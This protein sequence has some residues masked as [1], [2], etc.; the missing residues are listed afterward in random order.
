[1]PEVRSHSH[2]EDVIFRIGFPHTADREQAISVVPTLRAWLSQ[3]PIE[4]SPLGSIL[5]TGSCRA[6]IEIE[7]DGFWIIDEVSPAV[8]DP[9]R[10]RI[11]PSSGG[12]AAGMSMTAAGNIGMGT[13]T[14]GVRLDVVGDIRA[15]GDVY[16]AATLLTS[17]SRLKRN[18]QPIGNALGIVS[19]L[20]PVSYEKRADLKSSD[21]SMKQMGFIA[22]ELESVL[23]NSVQTDKSADAIKSVD[24]ISIIPVLTKALQEQQELIAKQQKEIEGLK[25]TVHELITR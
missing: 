4:R 14:P 17:D 5:V 18:L 7:A 12:E 13:A 25:K 3:W 1:M 15:S 9:E 6:A 2:T 21:Y 24:Y 11:F 23:P 20:R 8:G 16:S 10:L 22:Q 19:K